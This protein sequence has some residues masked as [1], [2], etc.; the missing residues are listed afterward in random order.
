VFEA[1]F[2]GRADTNNSEYKQQK[3][4]PTMLG[5][6]PFY[7][8]SL[9]TLTVALNDHWVPLHDTRFYNEVRE[10]VFGPSA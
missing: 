3:S 6:A 1:S 4:Y 2:K 9:F 10:G 8:C 5:T 7:T